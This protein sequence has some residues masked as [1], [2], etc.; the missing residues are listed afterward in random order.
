MKNGKLAAVIFTVCLILSGGAFAAEQRAVA[1]MYDAGKDDAAG[2]YR[3][4]IELKENGDYESSLGILQKLISGRKGYAQYEI[5]RLDVIIDQCNEMKEKK[6]SAWEIKAREAGRS[7]KLMRAANAGNGDYWVIYVKYATLVETKNEGHITK[8]LQ[9]AFYYKP[10]NPEA[11]I[12]QADYYF[13]CARELQTDPAQQYSMNTMGSDTSE[14]KANLVKSARDAY[15]A[16][17]AGPVSDARNAYILLRLGD[18][19]AR[20]SGNRDAARN[21]WDRA[22][23]L[24][25][26]AGSGKLAAQRL[27]EKK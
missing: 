16:A 27:R 17:L 23:K 9:K 22:A 20:I 24:A 25:P 1:S 8:A 3:Q 19:E 12:A 26:A 10:K 6:N 13:D 7:I 11:Y 18:M 4:A 14:A 2:M 5:A 15:Q 21:Y